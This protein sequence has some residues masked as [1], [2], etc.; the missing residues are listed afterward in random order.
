MS[1][2]QKIQIV[3]VLFLLA[4]IVYPN[5]SVE[6]QTC[7]MQYGSGGCGGKGCGTG[8]SGLKAISCRQ[9]ACWCGH[10]Q[11]CYIKEGEI[12]KA[13]GP[14]DWLFNI[15]SKQ[16]NCA[17]GGGSKS[18]QQQQQQQQQQENKRP[19]NS[20]L[21]RNAEICKKSWDCSKCAQEY[22]MANG[23]TNPGRSTVDMYNAGE[24]WGPGDAPLNQGDIII[25]ETGRGPN[26]MHAV[27]CYNA[28]CSLVISKNAGSFAVIKSSN[29]YKANALAVLRFK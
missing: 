27:T 20:Q 25:S 19:T 4:V 2:F 14:S 6:A 5:L 24:G 18:S 9:C 8:P 11:C 26:G 13:A 1:N 16:C 17:S 21:S 23:G 7:P 12:P 3:V 15:S 10:I 22:R 29:W 28:G